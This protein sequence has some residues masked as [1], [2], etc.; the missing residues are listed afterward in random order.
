MKFFGPVMRV[1]ATVFVLPLAVGSLFAAVPQH[2]SQS[3]IHPPASTHVKKPA[4]STASANA[5]SAVPPNELEQLSRALK[6]KNP[7][8]AYA[9]LSVFALAK[10]SGALGKRAALA[11]GYYDYGKAHYAQAATWLKLAQS[12]V[13]LHDYALY[14]S[15]QTNL[16]LNHNAEALAQLQQFRKDYPDSVITDQALQSLG[17]AALALNQP[18]EILAALDAYPQ[19]A[20]KPALLFLRGEARE[21][22]GAAA[23]GRRGLPNDL[24]AFPV[25]R[26]GSRS[27]RKAQSFCAA[28]SATSSPRFPSSSRSNTPP[29]FSPRVNGAMR[30]TNIRACCRNSP[31]RTANARNCASWNA[32]SRSAPA[33]PQS[34]RS[35]SPT[36][37]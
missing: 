5:P 6:Q 21:Q 37:T 18:A 1:V 13:L 29:R 20:E 36:P 8:A 35:R 30:A 14:W 2:A 11:L 24:F 25:E 3:Q 31:A 33:S 15:S 9:K 27:R 7:A 16:A 4:A 28:R 17:V 23:A 12:D 22:S 26:P 19:T 32:A 34:P 10:S